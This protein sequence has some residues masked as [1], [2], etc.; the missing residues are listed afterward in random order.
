MGSRYSAIRQI[1]EESGFT[2]YSP[3]F[4][5]FGKEGMPKKVMDLN[6]YITFLDGFLKKNVKGKPVLIGHSFG[7]RVSAKFAALY[8]DKIKALIL[9]GAP[10]I[11]KELPLRKKI[12][13]GIV[14]KAKGVV[15]S[16]LEETVR[17]GVYRFLG[18]W[19]YYKAGV[20]KETLKNILSEDISPF[21]SKIKV[22]TLLVWGE[23]DTFVSLAIGKE[24]AQKIQG[25][26]LYVVGNASHKLPYEYPETF[27]EE[28]L[29]FLRSTL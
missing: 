17:K 1:F 3:D 2:V 20:L 25:S 22:P 7:G 15:P 24:I 4:P 19:D 11:K 12:I 13:Q 14:K 9:S 29:T 5:G 21:L 27:A 16:F 28:V 23:K 6:D 8:P 18:E 10:L 26:S